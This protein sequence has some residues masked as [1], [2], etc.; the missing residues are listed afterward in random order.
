MGEDGLSSNLP[1]KRLYPYVERTV[2]ES[3]RFPI[4]F[5]LLLEPHTPSSILVG[6]AAACLLN[7][8]RYQAPELV[9]EVTEKRLDNVR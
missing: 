8:R 6:G 3:T 2:E 4:F 7:Y 9:L 5:L 1:G